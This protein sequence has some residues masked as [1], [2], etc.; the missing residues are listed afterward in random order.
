MRRRAS[1]ALSISASRVRALSHD[2]DSPLLSDP[3]SVRL[4]QAIELRAHI[5]GGLEARELV[6][7]DRHAA[8]RVGLD[9]PHLMLG[10]PGRF[11]ARHRV[12]ARRHLHGDAVPDR[13]LDPPAELEIGDPLIPLVAVLVRE[14]GARDDALGARDGEL[15]LEHEL[16]VAPALHARAAPIHHEKRERLRPVVEPRGVL[17]RPHLAEE[18]EPR[19]FADRDPL[20]ER[21]GVEGHVPGDRSPRLPPPEPLA[22]APPLGLL[23][24]EQVVGEVHRGLHRPRR[25]RHEHAQPDRRRPQVLALGLGLLALRLLLGLV[26]AGAQAV[27]GA[28]V[29]GLSLLLR[30][31]EASQVVAGG[32]ELE[33]LLRSRDVLVQVVGP[34][35][36][37]VEGTDEVVAGGHPAHVG[38]RAFAHFASSSADASRARECS[39]AAWSLFTRISRGGSTVRY[40]AT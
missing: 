31:E 12:L 37:G 6:H 3:G 28:R 17:D 9:P 5:V 1:S 7:G 8:L 11:H 39:T 35:E 22:A 30:R 27:V 16:L 40:S 34:D 33:E 24:L 14:V 13:V 10:Q 20:L 26:R 2:L 21:G 23:D 4:R 18:R 38:R 36:V 29:L 15:D 19:P 32:R 25:G